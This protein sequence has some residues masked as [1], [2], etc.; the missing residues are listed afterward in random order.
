M[1]RNK[2][3]EWIEAR[4]MDRNKDRWMDWRWMDRSKDRW[5]DRS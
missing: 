5:M 4:W 3:N 1:D 2:I